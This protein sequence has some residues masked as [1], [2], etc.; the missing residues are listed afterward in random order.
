M[1]HG[2]DGDCDG[3]LP[4]DAVTYADIIADGKHV[5]LDCNTCVE[6]DTVQMMVDRNAAGMR[7]DAMRVLFNKESTGRSETVWAEIKTRC[8]IERPGQESTV[9]PIDVPRVDSDL[10]DKAVRSLVLQLEKN[11]RG[12]EI[13]RTLHT[14]SRLGP[15]LRVAARDNVAS[16]SDAVRWG[17][18]IV[19]RE[20][21]LEESPMSGRPFGLPAHCAD[22]LEQ[23]SALRSRA[24]VGFVAVRLESM[25]V[26]AVTLN[27][28]LHS[29]FKSVF[30]MTGREV[31]NMFQSKWAAQNKSRKLVSRYYKQGNWPKHS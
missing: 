16:E 31:W 5:C 9:D 24:H 27:T 4:E 29:V 13:V 17:K 26:S 12:V 1:F 28:V 2:L 30:D 7:D 23:W 8:G 6:C 21:L 11:K 15:R 10:V 22:F 14:V 20:A 18:R 19:E 25:W 3:F